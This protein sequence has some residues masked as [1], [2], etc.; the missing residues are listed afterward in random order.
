MTTSSCVCGGMEPARTRVFGLAVRVLTGATVVGGAVALLVLLV[1]DPSA[2]ALA[3]AL[4]RVP[5][6]DQGAGT[7]GRPRPRRCRRPACG[8]FPQLR[9]PCRRGR[10][11]AGAAGIAGHCAPDGAAI[12]AGWR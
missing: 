12:A 11:D 2:P 3:A 10:L 9:P 4:R 1:R 8:S 5:S 7:F 6:A